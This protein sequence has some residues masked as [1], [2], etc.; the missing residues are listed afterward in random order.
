MLG[1]SIIIN[2]A[3]AESDRVIGSS[4]HRKTKALP[5][6]EDAGAA[7]TQRVIANG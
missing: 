3:Q 7:K 2:E 6:A 5:L 4:D 1:I